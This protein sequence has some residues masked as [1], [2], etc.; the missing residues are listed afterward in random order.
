MSIIYT[1]SIYLVK[2]PNAVLAISVAPGW[3]VVYC[4]LWFK[5]VYVVGG[6]DIVEFRIFNDNIRLETRTFVFKTLQINNNNNLYF[7]LHYEMKQVIAITNVY[8]YSLDYW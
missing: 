3:A 1:Y 4:R 7:T 5:F 8:W 2:N 6:D